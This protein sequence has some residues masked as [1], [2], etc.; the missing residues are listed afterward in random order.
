[1]PNVKGGLINCIENIA[2]SVNIK[3]SSLALMPPTIIAPAD[4]LSDPAVLVDRV[5]TLKH[6]LGQKM[7][8][9]LGQ[10]VLFLLRLHLMGLHLKQLSAYLFLML[11]L[12]VL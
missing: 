12:A 2:L 10:F 3:V 8:L 11:I 4:I 9:T 7:Q 6:F 1:M 5:Q